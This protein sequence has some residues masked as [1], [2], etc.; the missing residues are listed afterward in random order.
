MNDVFTR[1]WDDTPVPLGVTLVEVHPDPAGAPPLARAL[2]LPYAG[3]VSAFVT[4]EQSAR[5]A[6]PSGLEA[7]PDQARLKVAWEAPLP[8]S[9][10]PEHVLCSGDRAVVHG[11]ASWQ[12]HGPDGRLVQ[13]GTLANSGVLLDPGRGLFFFS[14]F[15]GLIAARKLA[16]GQPSFQAALGT[17]KEHRRT[18]LARRANRLIAVSSE[19]HL[20]LH[21]P[22]PESTAIEVA[23]LG[24]PSTQK[25]FP[26]PAGPAVVADLIRQTMAL[27]AAMQGQS[28]VLA[29][30]DRVYGL[31]LDLR[32]T[33]AIA[34]SFDPLS[35]SL[36]EAGRIYLVV[37]A[38]KRVALWVLAPGGARRYAFDL[39][40]GTAV[41]APPIVGFDHT[42][43]VMTDH[44]IFA[45][46][47]DGKLAWVRT[48]SGRFAGAV[49]TVDD[50]LLVADGREIAA[51]ERDGRRR[52][53]YAS[54]E[55]ELRTAPVVTATGEVLVASSKKLIALKLSA[56]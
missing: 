3:A 40:A 39:P 38:E 32:F 56:E 31:D 12:L 6:R 2:P 37:Q 1:Y 14:D 4:P 35:M 15:A 10:R 52:L 28:L 45:V 50:R 9:L 42:A 21:E 43:Y 25:S 27:L 47:P 5:V 53:L 44:Q 24:N 20:D 8:A 30:R 13:A 16:D 54:P 48:A 34:G 17:S 33:H 18:F 36:D 46:Q 22:A 26:D 7:L 29:T 23:D 19:L 11:E 41:K 51:F 55:D 49:V